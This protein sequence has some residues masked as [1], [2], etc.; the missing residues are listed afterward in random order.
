LNLKLGNP[1]ELD[2]YNI[3]GNGKCECCESRKNI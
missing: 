2:N 1:K 3:T